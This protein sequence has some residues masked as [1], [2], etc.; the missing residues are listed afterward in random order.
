MLPT[1]RL[2]DYLRASEETQAEFA[3]RA[4]RHRPSG[5]PI[6]Q[7]TI[8]RIA[9][10]SDCS[11]EIALAIVRATAEKPTLAGGTVT[12][13]DLVVEDEHEGRRA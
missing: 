5:E 6:M 2:R 4:S 7:T 3:E 11:A 8:S 1:M 10:G 13:E 12:L 9:A